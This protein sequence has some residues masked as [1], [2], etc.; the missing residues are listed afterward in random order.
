M[1]RSAVD[2][3]MASVRACVSMAL[4]LVA[5]ALAGCAAPDASP[6]GAG[7]AGFGSSAPRP[8]VVAIMDSGVNPYHAAFQAEPARGV[9][10]HADIFPEAERVRLSSEG[11]LPRR[12][13][14]D[15]AFWDGVEPGRL[16]A[17]S[18]TRVLAVTFGHGPGESPILDVPDHGTGVASLLA[19]TDPDA[20]IVV[21]QIDSNLCA[22]SDPVD[23]CSLSVK[24]APALQWIADQPWIDVVSLSLGMPLNPPSNAATDEETRAY[25]AAS[26]LLH[27]RGKVVVAAAGNDPAPSLASHYA[28]PP[29]MIAVGGFE[30]AQGGESSDASRAVDVLANYTEYVADAA[31]LD[32]YHW[33]G[34]TS[35]A[36]PLVAGT[37]SRAV[38]EARAAVG[39]AE[40]IVDGHLAPGL[41][42]TTFRAAL[43]ATARTPSATA[44]DPTAEP[45]NET[46]WNLV[47]QSVPVL[48]PGLQAGWGYVDGALAGEVARRVLE[49]DL[50]PPPEKAVT[51]RHMAE[52]HAWRETYWSRA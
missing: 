44:W 17:F 30:P 18:G 47:T 32:G 49:A 27:D 14:A 21:V 33:R 8:T 50:A 1:D 10:A 48:L 39:H 37:L 38:F 12:L 46:Y 6:P 42:G 34:G 20:L 11:G 35:Y 7:G 41:H 19:R 45:T 28:G 52:W 13:A 16:Y 4:L 40:G 3:S 24:I 26:R 31:T 43:N 29:W 36:A 5:G 22:P 25:L 15:G 9:D 2:A 23:G 51:A